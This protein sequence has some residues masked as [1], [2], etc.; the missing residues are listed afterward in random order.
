M[1]P[2]VFSSLLAP[3]LA[4]AAVAS[5]APRPR[6][7]VTRGEGYIRATINPITGIPNLRRRATEADVINQQD[8][9]RYAI[10]VEIGTPPQTLTLI[11]DTGSPD[12]WVNPRCDT[13]FDPQDCASYPQFDYTKSSSLKTSGFADILSYGKGNVTIEY[14]ADTVSIGC[15]LSCLLSSVSLLCRTD[16]ADPP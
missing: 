16:H 7:I 2:L 6:S 4:N 10:D 5:H 1:L 3:A 12:L 14:V 13:T 15:E 9:T 8:G 11:L